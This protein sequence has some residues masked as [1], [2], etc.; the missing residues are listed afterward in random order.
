MTKAMPGEI[1]AAV[2]VLF[3][4][5]L[6]AVPVTHEVTKCTPSTLPILLSTMVLARLIEV[7]ALLSVDG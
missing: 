1:S 2:L 4:F 5:L 3:L 7:R 6:V